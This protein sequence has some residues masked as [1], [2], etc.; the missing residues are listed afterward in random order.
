MPVGIIALTIIQE[1]I[2]AQEYMKNGLLEKWRSILIAV[3]RKNFYISRSINEKKI[4]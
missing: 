3:K 4:I 2:T 1:I